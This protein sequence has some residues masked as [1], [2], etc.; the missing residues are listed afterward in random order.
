M[1]II[2]KMTLWVAALHLS[3]FLSQRI[4][5]SAYQ[6]SSFAAFSSTYHGERDSAQE[7]L[8][9]LHKRAGHCATST[10]D[11]LSTIGTSSPAGEA[12]I[13]PRQKP[14]AADA[15]EN[16]KG[17]PCFLSVDIAVQTVPR[18]YT[19]KA[20]PCFLSVNIAGHAKCL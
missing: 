18:E 16:Q 20:K 11:A 2:S 13:C 14:K 9:R 8:L 3:C 1:L 19:H 5:T 6:I 12:T 15:P 7:L 17:K 10:Q 4:S